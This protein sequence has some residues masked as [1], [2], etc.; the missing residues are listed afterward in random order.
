MNKKIL[1]IFLLIVMVTSL[2]CLTACGGNEIVLKSAQHGS[3]SASH[4][5]AQKGKQVTITLSPDQGYRVDKVTV[6]GQE[7]QVDDNKVVF[8]MPDQAVS[9]EAT[10]V[11]DDYAI[12][13]QN[14]VGGTVDVKQRYMA[15]EQVTIKVVPSFGYYVQGL[16]VDGAPVS[17]NGDSYK[18]TM[19][20]KDVDVSASFAMSNVSA[21]SIPGGAVATISANAPAGGTATSKWY[22]A[23][24]DQKVMVTAYVT[25][26]KI[27]SSK[28]GIVLYCGRNNYAN[29]IGADNHSVKVAPDGT[30]T[31]QNGYNGGFVSADNGGVSANV[32]VLSLQGNAVDGYIVVVNLPYEFLGVTKDNAQSNLTLLPYLLNGDREG[33]AFGATEGTL[34]EFYF[35]SNPNTYPLVS[36]QGFRQN[37]YMFGQGELGSYKDILAQ[38]SQW[39]TSQDYSQD[40]ANYANRKVTLNG[41]D[42]GDNNIA[43]VRSAG[44]TSF[45]KATF[46][47]NAL[48]NE[49]ERFPKFGF[50]VYDTQIANSGVFMYVDAYAAEGK[51][52]GIKL[53]DLVGTSLGYASQLKG[54]WLNWTTLSGTEGMF[55]NNTKTITLS[56]CYNNGFVY[57]FVEVGGQDVLVGVTT[58]QAQGDIVISIKS[59]ALGL[60]VTN[61]FATNDPNDEMFKTHN[62]RA[63]GTTIGDNASG[64]AYTEGWNFI[65]DLAENTGGGDQI[66]YIKGVTASTNFYAQADLT[67]PTKVGNTGDEYTK[68]GAVLKNENYTIMGYIDL[69]D[70]TSANNRVTCNFAVRFDS[71]DRLGQWI[72]EA[73]VSSNFGVTIE[74]KFVTVGIAKLG[75]RVYLTMNGTIVATYYNK[76]IE[77][78]S[79]VAGMMGFNRSMMVTNGSGTMDVEQVK[80]KIGLTTAENVAFDGV[81]NDSIW[82]EQVLG[83]TQTFADQGDGRKVQIAAVKGQ[84]GVF[85]AL[86]LYTNTMQRQFA[87]SVGWSEA[88][89]VEF[90]LHQMSD[91]NKTNK[92]LVHYVAFYDF[93]DGD[94]TTS[95]SFLNAQSK[96]EEVTF[97]NGQKGY[98][99][100]VE[101][102]IPYNYFGNASSQS[103]LPIYVW[104]ATFDDNNMPA[105]N[106]TYN[107]QIMYVTDNGLVVENI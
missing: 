61:Y 29:K 43:F 53:I 98:K 94:V 100:T 90:R 30:V 101:F 57:F 52:S 68:V 47:V 16:V 17:L 45:V 99:V 51:T 7:Q 32:R 18:F 15:G 86:T 102:F 58:Y 82:T 28:D 49:Y 66:V 70:H 73:G 48:Y 74:D 33:T 96:L 11:T 14:S 104:T 62:Q 92:N 77:D 26:S 10:F 2:L 85:V 19:P 9:V 89:N 42:G 8:E 12:N 103:K 84:D 93:L 81:L 3:M 37:S 87:Q 91:N 71:G 65:G 55:N 40:H 25:D 39:N 50:M 36:V 31:V 79:F 95:A 6:N 56:V 24:E 4:T 5:S 13:V 60:E 1:V 54:S 46:K 20:Q 34:D 44:T 107:Q 97:E 78:Q 22:L 21:T 67:S 72:W 80:Q 83:S 27:L 88:C 23:F 35:S 69:N 63:D 106:R 41:H 64:Y 105:M 76:D 59:F 38:G 75:P